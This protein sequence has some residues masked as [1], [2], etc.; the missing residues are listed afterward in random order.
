MIQDIAWVR[1]LGV[2]TLKSHD[3]CRPDEMKFRRTD[4]PIICNLALLS[5]IADTGWV[6]QEAS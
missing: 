5:G 4:K 3:A 6:K 1:L 2:L